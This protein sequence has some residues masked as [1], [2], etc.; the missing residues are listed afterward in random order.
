MTQTLRQ[1][2]EILQLSTL[3]LSEKISNELLENP[4]LEEESASFS[5]TSLTPENE[6]LG[7]ISQRLSG[8]EDGL[9][10]REESYFGDDYSDTGYSGVPD[11]DRKRKYIENAVA[12]EE[13]LKDHLL[14]QARLSILDEKDL[15]IV[16][17]I[18]TSINDSG[19]LTHS[20]ETLAEENSLPLEELSRLL[21]IIQNFDPVGCG[22]G[23]VQETLL[24]QAAHFFPEDRVLPLILRDH[25]TDL[26]RLQYERI[27]RSLGL[28]M[29]DVIQKS[30]IIQNLDPFPGRQYSSRNVRY[31][32][33]DIEVRYIDEE[34]LITFNDEWVPK[35]RINSYY[36]ALLR[37]KNIEKNLKEYIQDKLQSAKHLI[38]NLSSRRDTIQ[39]VVKAIMERQKDFLMKGPGN[40]KP[41][42]HTEIAGELDL[43]ESTVSRATSGKFVQTSWGVFELKYFFVSRVKSSDEDDRSSDEAMNLIKDVVASEDPQNPFTDEEILAKLNKSGIEVARRTIAKYRGILGI[44]PSNKRK[45]INMIKTEESL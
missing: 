4:I 45:K 17:S 1:S 28:T 34:I 7:R 3:E 44:P 31:V 10:R 5:P 41:L 21:R 12:Q 19:F 18:I 11:D 25:F 35:I 36:A 2:I 6:M 33:P 38:R 16:E 32:I 20:L 14:W 15:E 30:K 42:T 37:K 29:G 24:V 8:G 9:Q 43:H 39:R 27:A 13:T 26:E 23:S 22:S 40:L